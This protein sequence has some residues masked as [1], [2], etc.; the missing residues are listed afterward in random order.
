LISTREPSSDWSTDV[1]AAFESGDYQK[2]SKIAAAEYQRSGDTGALLHQFNA[3]Y[4]AKRWFDFSNTLD[5]AGDL[6][7]SDS[8]DFAVI[9]LLS[10]KVLMQLR[11]I[12]AAMKIVDFAFESGEASFDHELCRA[13]ITG[14]RAQF[15]QAR[16]A[17]EDMNRTYPR[18]PHILRRIIQVCEQQRDYDAAGGFLRVALKMLPDDESLLEK[19]TRYEVLGMY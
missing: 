13:S 9:R 4:R 7:F 16:S 18:N 3:M 17:L 12:D 8:P 2:A 19:R 1:V 11:K 6:I 14:M 10:I 5:R 15:D